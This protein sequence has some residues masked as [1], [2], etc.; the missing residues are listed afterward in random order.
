MIKKLSHFVNPYIKLK[1]SK[2][3]GK[4]IYA[5]KDIKKGT[6]IIEY[7]GKKISKEK[8]DEIYEEQFERHKNNPEK[9]GSVYTFT[10]DD[11]HDLDGNVWWN[12]AKYIN[13]SC[14][15]NCESE[16]GDG[17]II[18]RAIKNI[19]KGEELSFN[20]GYDVENYKDHPCLCG[21]KNCVGH[22]VAQDQ[23]KK[24]EILKNIN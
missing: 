3:H 7:L 13:H 20:Y 10:L 11:K 16:D 2:I 14:N 23:W 21:S 9:D 4:G 22:I 12:L 5:K 19:K 8:S 15:P 18:I 17:K 6:E 24:L 1:N